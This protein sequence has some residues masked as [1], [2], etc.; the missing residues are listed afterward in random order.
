MSEPAPFRVQSIS[1]RAIA[2]WEHKGAAMSVCGRRSFR[3]LCLGIIAALPLLAVAAIS[4]C[5]GFWDPL[6]S[7]GS[8]TN[9][10]SGVFYVLNQKTDQLAGLTFASGASSPTAVSGS[11]Y[12]LSS[13]P[14]AI[15]ITPS[16]SYLY[17]STLGGITFYTINSDGSLTASNQTI[18]SDPAYSMQV[19]PSGSWLVEFISGSNVLAALPLDSSTGALSGSAQT[20]NLPASTPKQ[21]AISPSGSTSPYV[22]VAM[23]SGGT[24][25]IPFTSGNSDPF[26]SVSRVTV[27]NSAGGDN[28]VAVDPQNPLLYVGETAAASGTQ[29]GGLRVF[30]IG[31]SG[32]SEIYTGTTDAA[33]KAYPYS[34]GGTGPSAIL[35]TNGYVYVANSAV[36]GSSNGN[37]SG[38]FINTSG[39][40]YLTAINT[41]STG[42]QTMSIAEDSTDAYILAVNYG[43][44]PDLSTFTFDS[45]TAGQLDAGPTST[46]GTDPVGAWSIVAAP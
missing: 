33:G 4:G 15:A 43:G 39:N 44:S 40:Y 35:V 16:G 22:F 3:K 12:S 9:P 18:S 32:I 27:R 45:T 2:F 14:Q 21:I 20:V 41:V 31:T 37:I 11:P 13:A 17:V 19:D 28:A 38:F 34:T 24:A 7:S 8:G 6:P 42:P 10:S 26:G 36:S 25:V 1:Y 29:T 23:G 46:T 5:A 30:K